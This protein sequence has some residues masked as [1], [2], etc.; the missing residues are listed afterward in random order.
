MNNNAYATLVG[1]ILLSL[2]FILAGYS[3]LT[4]IAGTAGWFGSLG[5][6]LPTVAAVV[7]GLV[8]LV[9]GLAI[10]VGFHARIAAL[11]LAAFTIGATLIAHM[12]LEDPMQVLMIQKNLAITGGL[13]I[14]AALGAGALSIDARRK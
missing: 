14:L 12:D 2:L 3:K 13:L 8:E 9:G 10:L 7:I 5:I 6:P 1:R 11:V 4:G